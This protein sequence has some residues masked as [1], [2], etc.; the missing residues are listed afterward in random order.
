[1]RALWLGGGPS[2]CRGRGR[3]RRS[4]RRDGRYR[5]GRG[6]KGRCCRSGQCRGGL[7]DVCLHLVVAGGRQSVW[8]VCRG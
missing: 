2:L 7:G 1:M 6:L 4:G 5:T 8:T 3:G